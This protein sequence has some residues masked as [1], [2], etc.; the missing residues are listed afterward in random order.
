MP[1]QVP[2]IKS[3]LLARFLAARETVGKDWRSKLADFEPYFNTK[4]G[5]DDM[6]LT[7]QAVNE[8]QR[9]GQVDRIKRVVLSLERMAGIPHAMIL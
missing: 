1:Y 2:S 9:R 5:V 6:A 3:Q 7:A 4:A 8:N